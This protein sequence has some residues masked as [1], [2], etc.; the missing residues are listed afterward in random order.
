MVFNFPG[1]SLI[2]TFSP[3]VCSAE[4]SPLSVLLFRLHR[5]TLPAV[6]LPLHRILKRQPAVMVRPSLWPNHF[7]LSHKC[8][9]LCAISITQGFVFKIPWFW[10]MVPVFSTFQ[11]LVSLFRFY[12]NECNS[13]FIQENGDSPMNKET[14]EKIHLNFPK[15]KLVLMISAF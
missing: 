1:K 6:L 10:K 2:R 4:A 9:L 13:Y 14:M 8:Y 12:Y 11:S 15:A 5:L 7:S 3:D